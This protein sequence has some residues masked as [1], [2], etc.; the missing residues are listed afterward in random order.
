MRWWSG[1]CGRYRWKR[2][3]DG[4]R[5]Q[6]SRVRVGMALRLFF[7]TLVLALIGAISADEATERRREE[8][9]KQMRALAEKTRIAIKGSDRQPEFLKSPIFR[10]DDQPRRFIDAT[11][12]AWT[13]QGRPVAFQ[14]IEAVE[15]G[16]PAAPDSTWQ[17]CFAS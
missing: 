7:A 5:S 13:D 4:V 15:F 14:K 9:L 17:Y 16:D 12:W 11:I 10:Y 2:T 1:C 8:L 3:E 6:D